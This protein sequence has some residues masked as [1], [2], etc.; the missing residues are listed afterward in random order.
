[1]TKR[2]KI[3]ILRKM[4][5]NILNDGGGFCRAYYHSVMTATVG[6]LENSVLALGLKKPK[7]CHS[8]F[9]WYSLTNKALRIRKIDELIKRLSK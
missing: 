6:E 5:M 2:E 7:K 8:C 1:M 9:H 4:R 3:S